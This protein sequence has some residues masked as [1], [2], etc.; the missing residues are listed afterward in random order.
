MK[1]F[2]CIAIEDEAPA[3]G[4]LQSYLE[5]FPNF[6]LKEHFTSALKARDYLKS[7][8][9]DVL[10]LDI[11]LPGISGMEFLKVL[12][13]PPLVV[14][15]S[16]YD[17][18]AIEAFGLE[19]FDYLLKPYSLARF[20]RTIDRIERHMKPA[21]HHDDPLITVKEGWDYRRFRFSEL[22]YIE[23]QREY[24]LF[25]LKNGESYKVRMTMEEGLALFPTNSMI[26]IHRSFI[27][28]LKEIKAVSHS[29]VTLS[30]KTLPLGRSYRNQVLD[31]WRNKSPY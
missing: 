25:F 9:V 31:F 2:N 6:E 29:E 15:T 30:S 4:L 28:P 14:I 1:S 10:F 11:Q 20:T 12:E 7:N 17:E 21:V 3:I 16:A 18:H 13:N 22:C 27:V 23:S 24:L 26:R 19:V 8:Q 5:Y